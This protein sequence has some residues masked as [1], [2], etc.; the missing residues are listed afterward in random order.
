MN[1]LNR[2]KSIAAPIKKPPCTTFITRFSKDAV[3]IGQGK[4]R[5]QPGRSIIVR[6]INSQHAIMFTTQTKCQSAVSLIPIIAYSTMSEKDPYFFRISLRTSG[7]PYL[8]NVKIVRMYFLYLS[9]SLQ[10]SSEQSP[11]GQVL[12]CKRMNQCCNSAEG[13]SYTA[14]S[15]TKA[16]ELILRP[17]RHF[18]YV[19][20]NSPTFPLLHLRH[21]S[22]SNPYF[23]SPTTQ[24]LHLIHLASRPCNG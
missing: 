1:D 12:H 22:F 14:N 7:K 5:N 17:F 3:N 16:A 10:S 23:A 18:I 4:Y 19:T 11:Q 20:A 8:T 24:V 2:N 13:R 9:N 6:K 15:G 21:S